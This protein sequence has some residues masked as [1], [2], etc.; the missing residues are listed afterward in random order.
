MTIT[1]VYMYIK[2]KHPLVCRSPSDLDPEELDLL[3]IDYLYIPEDTWEEGWVSFS[4]DYLLGL[5]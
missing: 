5:I 4:T 3:G 1:L 2:S